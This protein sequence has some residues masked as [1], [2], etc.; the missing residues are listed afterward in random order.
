VTG[1]SPYKAGDRVRPSDLTGWAY[2][3]LTGKPDLD[4]KAVR[5]Y[6]KG[7]W[8]LE[9][10]ALSDW[11]VAARVVSC[12]TIQEDQRWWREAGRRGV[13]PRKS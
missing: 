10:R 2:T 11:R 6:R 5:R 7:D 8:V 4:P 1:T 9:L 12:R 13:G 3:G